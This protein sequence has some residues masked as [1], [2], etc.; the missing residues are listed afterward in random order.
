MQLN[1]LQRSLVD[2][3]TQATPFRRRSCPKLAAISKRRGA[4]APCPAAAAVVE[5][6]APA[7]ATPSAAGQEQALAPFHLAIP[8]RDLAEAKRFYGGYR[9]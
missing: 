2:Q 4:S 3:E 6:S 8:V 7:Q 5:Q 1:G 9:Q